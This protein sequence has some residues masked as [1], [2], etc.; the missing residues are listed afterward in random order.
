MDVQLCSWWFLTLFMVLATAG[1]IAAGLQSRRTN[2]VIGRSGGRLSLGLLV[3][4]GLLGVFGLVSL[5]CG[6]LITDTATAWQALVDYD[7]ADRYQTAI[8]EFRIGRTILA[9]VAGACLAVSGAVTQGITRNPLGSPGL[10]GVNAGAAFAIVSAI[11]FGGFV[12]P[13]E[14]VW[15]AFIGA[16]G[17]AA[18]VYAVASVGHAGATP[19]KLALAGAVVSALLAAWTTTLLLVDQESL[20]EARFWLA[21]SVAGRRLEDLAWLLPLAAIG[22]IAAMALGRQINALTLGDEVARGLGQR[23]GRVR[24]AAGAVA[25]VL[26]GSAV[27]IAGPVAF[28]GLAVPH[29]VRAVV[30]PD[31]R[32]IIPYSALLGPCMLLGADVVGRV[33]LRPTEVQVGIVAAAIGAPFL[34]YLVRFTKL[35]EL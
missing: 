4:L 31:Y 23:T 1:P 14:Y 13:L 12:S 18:L 9:A 5:R 24:L 25:V 3:S 30:G 26:A 19:V 7:P 20:E 2:A 6:S 22:L 21:G 35:A 33:V 28:I 16:A 34:I 10:L 11:F 8:R 32:W 15:F 29:L 27:S 17:A